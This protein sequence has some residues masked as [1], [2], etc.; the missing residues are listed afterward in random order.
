MMTVPAERDSVATTR[1]LLVS[2]HTPL[3]ATTAIPWAWY[4]PLSRSRPSTLVATS[5]EDAVDIVVLKG[6]EKRKK[7][8]GTR[9]KT[10]TTKLSSCLRSSFI[11]HSSLPL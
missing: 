7:E 8:G 9:T 1:R 5:T 2:L 4:S 3:A 6:K 11:F 10:K